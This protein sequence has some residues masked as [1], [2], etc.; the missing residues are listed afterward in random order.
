MVA[1]DKAINKARFI[2][3]FGYFKVTRSFYEPSMFHENDIDYIARRYDLKIDDISS[4]KIPLPS[5][6]K[7]SVNI[8]A[9]W[10]RTNI[11]NKIDQWVSKAY[12]WALYTQSSILCAGRIGYWLSIWSTILYFS[13]QNH[14]WSNEYASSKYLRKVEIIFGS[15]GTATARAFLQTDETL[16]GRYTIAR[17][18]KFSH[19][20]KPSKIKE[21]VRTYETL[22]NIH[23]SLSDIIRDI[24]L[25]ENTARHYA[26]WVE[27]AMCTKYCERQN[28]NSS[29]I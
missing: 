15:Y 3:M 28:T 16:P 12:R 6:K 23:T 5:T 22:R 7:S 9:I 14:H 4:A 25:E 2:A 27:K 8:S 29:S 18:K 19:S 13:F 11:S 20:L 1:I 17:F 10:H 21:E 24:G 26:Q